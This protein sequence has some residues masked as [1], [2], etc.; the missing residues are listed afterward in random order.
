MSNDIKY[1]QLYKNGEL[2]DRIEQ[3]QSIL[4]QCTL[5][6]RNCKVDRNT[7][8]GFC[9]TGR[10]AKISSYGTHFGEESPLVGKYGSGTIF[11]ANCNLGCVFCQNYTIS[12]LGQGNETDK[13]ELANI[14]IKLQKQGC[15]NINFVSPSHVVTQ[16]IESLP[17]A[18]EMGLN[19]PLV[20]NTGGY[21]NIETLKLLDGIIDIY[22]PDMKYADN[23]VAYELS[24]VK[25]YY[26]TNTKAVKLMHQQVGDLI[27]ENGIAKKGLLVRHLVLPDNLSGS[28]K[29]FEFLATEISVNT[30]LNIMNQYH[31][32][33]KSDIID[34][35]NRCITANEYKTS[36]GFAKTYNLNRLG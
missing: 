11:F 3:L 6:P 12:H 31:P 29:I 5:C 30:Y 34:N 26:E 16:I 35:L 14:M 2:Q 4:E 8:L 18:I 10:L 23:E 25:D 36:I 22:M 15:H 20:Y 13:Y 32:S 9:R 19:V 28:K 7:S 33:Y 24:Y 21:D 27:I 1:I 17:I